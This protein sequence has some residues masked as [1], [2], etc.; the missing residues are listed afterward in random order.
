MKPILCVFADCIHTHC[1]RQ[2]RSRN[3]DIE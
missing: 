3:T 2:R 1:N